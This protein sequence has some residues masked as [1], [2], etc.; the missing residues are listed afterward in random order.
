MTKKLIH[1]LTLRLIT[2]TRKL[3]AEQAL[4]IQ[5]VRCSLWGRL[6]SHTDVPHA[7]RQFVLKIS[8]HATQLTVIEDALACLQ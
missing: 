6:G 7:L 1:K 5:A 2:W 8:I 3:S 4:Q